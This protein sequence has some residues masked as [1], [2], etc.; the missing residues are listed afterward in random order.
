MG[1]FDRELGLLLGLQLALGV[2]EE[3]GEVRG[4][5]GVDLQVGCQLVDCDQQGV[6]VL[7]L[8]LDGLLVLA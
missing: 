8:L 4:L 2:G 1:G 7:A 5:V 6:D 3:V